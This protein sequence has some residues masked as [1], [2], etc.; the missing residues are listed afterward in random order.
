M[1]FSTGM[2]F[3]IRRAVVATFLAAG[4]A[5]CSAQPGGIASLPAAIHSQPARS[6]RSSSLTLHVHVPKKP[7]RVRV[8]IAGHGISHYISASTKG[9]TIAVTGPTAVNEAIGLL[10]QSSNCASG[11]TGISCTI[12]IPA[13]ASCPSAANCYTATIATYDQPPT[14]A[15]SCVIPTGAHELSAA[16]SVPFTITAGK[17]ND[18]G[19]TLD[20]VPASLA[21]SS[22]TQG[23]LQGTA[24]QLNL[25]GPIAQQ[26]TVTALDADHNAIV[27]AGSP[28][29]TGT[30]TSNTLT[31]T[32]P[33]SSAPNLLTLQAETTGTLPVVTPGNVTL[34]LTAKPPVG[35]PVTISVPLTIAHSAVYVLGYSATSPY[36][37]ELQA[38]YDGNTTAN[39]NLTVTGSNTGLPAQGSA[40]GVTVDKNGKVYA[41][42]QN[43][44]FV[45]EFTA[46]AL[47]PGGTLNI[48]P[49]ATLS[50]DS[51][52]VA[53]LAVD[54]TNSLFVNET[55]EDDIAEFSAGSTGTTAPIVTITASSLGYGLALDA[56]GTVYSSAGSSIVEYAAGANGSTPPAVTI[57]GAAT[58]LNNPDG[59]AVDAFGDVFAANF[60]NDTVTEYAPNTTGNAAPSATITLGVIAGQSYRPAAVAVDAQGTLFVGD[61]N[62]GAFL[63]YTAGATGTATPLVIAHTAV[64]TCAIT[65]VPAAVQP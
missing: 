14:C 56:N 38:Y 30:T 41:G 32:N 27:G 11:A 55:L 54:S 31:V 36:P 61:N 45:D 19:F 34:K 13:L 15:P 35:T 25:W 53:G 59:V 52:G 65:V 49:S 24:S 47:Q 28:A 5:A 64:D 46:S 57:A 44:G 16:Q 42:F 20:A 33:A 58:G 39:A 4:L 21:V 37:G 43:G 12:T 60:N 3:R 22:L 29:I 40:C 63:E 1:S 7:R 10:A 26:L 2:S 51:Y 62:H 8:R 48:V 50:D 9:M 23:Y 18:V 17:A 6:V